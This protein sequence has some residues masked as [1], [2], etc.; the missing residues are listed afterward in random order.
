MFP[1]H[2]FFVHILSEIRSLA[3][4]NSANSKLY[5]LHSVFTIFIFFLSKIFL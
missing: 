5:N 2:I 4:N 3:L 1:R